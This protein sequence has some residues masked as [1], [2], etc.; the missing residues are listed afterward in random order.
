MFTDLDYIHHMYPNI[1]RI[2]KC[3]TFSQARGIF[4]FTDS[5]NIGACVRVCG[6]ACMRVCGCVRGCVRGCVCARARVCK[7]VQNYYTSARMYSN[8]HLRT[9][10]LTHYHF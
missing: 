1:V 5:D 2:Q 6:C 4:G 8:A 7:R 10:A 9:H 3:V